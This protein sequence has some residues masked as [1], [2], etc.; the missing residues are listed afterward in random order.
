MIQALFVERDAEAILKLQPPREE[1]EDR[2][3]WNLSKDGQY[4]VKGAYSLAGDLAGGNGFLH[5]EG[6]WRKLW[7]LELPPRMKHHLWR[8]AR[9]VLPTRGAL[10]ARGVVMED[11]CGLCN[12][13]GEDVTHLFL[14]CEVAKRCWGVAGGA[15]VLEGA[16][17]EGEDWGWWCMRIIRTKSQEEVRRM[18]MVVWGLWKERNERVWNQKS[19]TEEMVIKMATDAVEE[20][21]EVVM[22]RTGVVREM[23]RF[24]DIEWR[25]DK[26]AHRSKNVKLKL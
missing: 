17:G 6:E 3:V 18:A 11:R 19:M 9:G 13:E 24:L 15:D 16:D 4:S 14:T 25:V 20:W 1:V 22:R 8:A 26:G 5:V 21:R 2:V 7:R 12:A 10:N 23:G